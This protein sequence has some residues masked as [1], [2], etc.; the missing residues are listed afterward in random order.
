M[1]KKLRCFLKK[2]TQLT[3]IL[4]DRRSWRSRQIPSLDDGDGG[5]GDGVDD[6]DLYIMM[7]H[8]MSGSM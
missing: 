4:H 5:D 1:C 2:I 8:T 7:M 3:K 6:D